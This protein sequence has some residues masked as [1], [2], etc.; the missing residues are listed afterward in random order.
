MCAGS[1]GFTSDPQGSVWTRAPGRRNLGP[2]LQGQV[3]F[4]Q[5]TG[6]S[7]IKVELG[8]TES[9]LHIKDRVSPESGSES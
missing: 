5:G 9:A 6:L 7:S 2:L 1:Q 4:L 3:L 8:R